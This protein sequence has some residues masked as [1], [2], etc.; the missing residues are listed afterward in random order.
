MSRSNIFFVEPSLDE[1]TE[2]KQLDRLAA[3]YN[4]FIDLHLVPS[5]LVEM[6]FTFQILTVKEPKNAEKSTKQSQGKLS[7]KNCIILMLIWKQIL[8]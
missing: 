6:Y 4:L 1:V 8:C 2:K 3:L 5:I 7:N